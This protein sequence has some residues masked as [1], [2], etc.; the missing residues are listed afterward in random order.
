M[1]RVY[2]LE[3]AVTV[4]TTV[5]TYAYTWFDATKY[6]PEGATG[7]Y[8]SVETSKTGGGAA[9]L[10]FRA[11]PRLPSIKAAWAGSAV[12]P[13]NFA[14][15]IVLPLDHR[16]GRKAFQHRITGSTFTTSVSI[17]LLGYVL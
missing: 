13:L 10:E 1:S 16:T 15:T 6:V 5:T 11:D 2:W 17:K 12:S 14:T 9:V 7:L 8:L 4:S 3:S